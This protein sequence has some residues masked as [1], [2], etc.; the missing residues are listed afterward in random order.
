MEKEGSVS[1]AEIV[2]DTDAMVLGDEKRNY[3]VEDE[4]KAVQQ[5]SAKVCYQKCSFAGNT[6]LYGN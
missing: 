3:A 4:K 1:E 5:D 6:N 2:T